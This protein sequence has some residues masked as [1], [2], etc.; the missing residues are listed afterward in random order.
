MFVQDVT[1]EKH[2]GPEGEPRRWHVTFILRNGKTAQLFI[3]ADDTLADVVISLLDFIK[4]V[5]RQ[6]K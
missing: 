1:V 2:T 3:R 4:D 5:Q 6:S